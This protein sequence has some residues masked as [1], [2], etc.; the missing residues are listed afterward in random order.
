M[1]FRL[2][3]HPHLD[4]NGDIQDQAVG[5]LVKPLS[6]TEFWTSECPGISS[7]VPRQVPLR[8]FFTGG[9]QDRDVE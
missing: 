5:S 7:L 2:L 8:V 3:P 1:V 9:T 6:L 4:S